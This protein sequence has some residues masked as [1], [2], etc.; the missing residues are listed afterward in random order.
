[1]PPEHEKERKQI[2]STKIFMEIHHA[3]KGIFQESE[4]VHSTWRMLIDK[5]DTQ[6]K[7]MTIAFY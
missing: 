6:S 3:H 5:D 4:D 1:M 7:T 2:Y